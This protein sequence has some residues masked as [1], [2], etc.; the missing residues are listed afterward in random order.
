MNTDNLMMVMILGGITLCGAHF[1]AQYMDWR[2]QQ[3]AEVEKKIRVRLLYR[4]ELSRPQESVVVPV[5]ALAGARVNTAIPET[6]ET[7]RCRQTLPLR[8]AA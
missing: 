8:K 6:V 1:R 4:N 3:I 5:A 2:N 7:K